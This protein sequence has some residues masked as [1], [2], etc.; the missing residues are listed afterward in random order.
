MINERFRNRIVVAMK[1]HRKMYPSAVAQANVLGISDSQ[2]SRIYKGDLDGVLSDKNWMLIANQLEVR[3]NPESQ[4]WKVAQTVTFKKIYA[5]LEACQERSLSGVFCDSADIGKTF[6]AKVYAKEHRNCYYIDCSQTKTKRE[7][8]KAI[9]R[10]IG[11]HYGG[12]YQRIYEDV[13][14]SLNSIAQP[15]IILDEV[16]DLAYPA[17]LEIKALWNATERSCGWYMMGADG[18][19]AKIDSNREKSKVGY[20]EIFSRFGSR[21]QRSTPEG[22]DDQTA[23]KKQQFAEIAKLN[24][25]TESIPK[26]YAS[27]DGSLRRVYTEIQKTKAKNSSK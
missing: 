14:T 26:L 5:Q 6:T 22:T 15:M 17:F 27:C 4:E 23:F 10:Q 8:I 12:N 21:Y 9:A 24:G 18:L 1:E 19:K 3:I 13:I 20:A 7:L 16:G 11:T 25:V 2:L